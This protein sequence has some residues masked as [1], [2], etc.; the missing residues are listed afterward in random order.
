VTVKGSDAVVALV[1]TESEDSR[2]QTV[3]AE[4]IPGASP[5]AAGA[6]PVGG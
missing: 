2:G 5:L 1:Q 3:V 6:T 4:V